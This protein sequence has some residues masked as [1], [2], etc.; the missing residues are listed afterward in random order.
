MLAQHTVLN[1]V[2]RRGGVLLL[3]PLLWAA[4]CRVGL[5]PTKTCSPYDLVVGGE[6]AA[7]NHHNF[8]RRPKEQTPKTKLLSN[9]TVVEPVEVEEEAA[10][11]SGC[12][13]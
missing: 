4:S 13:G 8:P 7:G 12:R 5:E 1:T 11:S 3:L 2:L 10:T 6:D 9:S